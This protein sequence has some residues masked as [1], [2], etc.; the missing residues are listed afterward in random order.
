[1]KTRRPLSS[2]LCL[3]FCLA[4][5]IG[6]SRWQTY[7]NGKLIEAMQQKNRGLV[8]NLLNEGADANAKNYSGDPAIRLAWDSSVRDLLLSRG[9]R[10]DEHGGEGKTDLMRAAAAGNLEQL[11]ADLAKGAKL[12]EKDNDGMTPFRHAA[13]SRQRDVMR[14]LIEQHPEAIGPKDLEYACRC[15]AMEDDAALMGFLVEKGAS[16]DQSRDVAPG[17]TYLE[18][19]AWS[20]KPKIVKFLLEHHVAI[21]PV[22]RDGN[23]PLS[24][25]ASTGNLPIIQML[26]EAGANPDGKPNAE[27]PPLLAATGPGPGKLEV[28]QLLLGRHAKIDIRGKNGWTPIYVAARE[29]QVAIAKILIQA[30]ANVNSE[31]NQ[32][33]TPLAQAS[34]A[35]NTE[36]VALLLEHGANVDSRNDHGITPI[37]CA[38][39]GYNKK[40]LRLETVRLLLDHGAALGA[41]DFYMK[42]PLI[43]AVEAQ[44]ED[45]VKLILDRGG[46]PTLKIASGNSSGQSA[47]E[48]AGNNTRKPEIKALLQRY[49]AG[50]RTH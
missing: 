36:M 35:C 14:Y 37:L 3:V 28:V 50:N 31:T 32:G 30:G 34:S 8:I 2:R 17:G 40:E 38:I 27:S 15:A 22:D 19:A 12:T 25:A 4:L 23:T 6:C 9:A 39:G 43:M 18:Q 45:L 1:M 48:A 5:S 42:T 16:L 41:H 33:E 13:R 11:K 29:K 49:A 24:R 26:L 20:Q 21:D 47:I 7:L 10:L 46:D 44:D